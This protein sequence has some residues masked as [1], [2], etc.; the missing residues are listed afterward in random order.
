MLEMFMAHIVTVAGNMAAT[1]RDLV[2]KLVA[3]EIQ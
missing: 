3:N 2:I 1:A